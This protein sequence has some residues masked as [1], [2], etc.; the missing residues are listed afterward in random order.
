M[1]GWIG[2]DLDGTL[3]KSVA[4]TDVVMKIADSQKQK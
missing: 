4:Q 3:A 2:V 1:R